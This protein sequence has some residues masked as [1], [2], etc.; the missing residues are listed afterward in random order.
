[1]P[2]K[3]NTRMQALEEVRRLEAELKE[4]EHRNSKLNVM[5]RNAKDKEIPRL[6]AERADHLYGFVAWLTTRPEITRLG[7]SENCVPVMDFL[8]QYMEANDI[9]NPSDGYPKTFVMPS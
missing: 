7:S 3:L 2:V 9:G 8:K 1:M 5:Y 6:R 4:A